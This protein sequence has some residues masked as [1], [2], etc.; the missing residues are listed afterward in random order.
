[1]SDLRSQLGETFHI[2]VCTHISRHTLNSINDVHFDV[3]LA[4]VRTGAH[5]GDDDG[6]EAAVAR[7]V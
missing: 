4:E 1:M 2:S 6:G 5:E 3:L 7:L